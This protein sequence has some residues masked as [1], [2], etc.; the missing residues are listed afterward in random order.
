MEKI[1]KLPEENTKAR[2]VLDVFLGF[3][4]LLT[5]IFLS[6]ATGWAGTSG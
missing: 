5:I 4:F 2:T 6:L 1:L 3:I